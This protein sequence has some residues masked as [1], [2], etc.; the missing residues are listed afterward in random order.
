MITDIHLQNFRSYTDESFELSPGVN[1][2]V[3]PNASGKTNLL[4]AILVSSKGRSY[5]ASDA[6][7]VQFNKPSARIAVHTQSNDTRIVFIELVGEHAIKQY[8]INDHSL[9]RMV[10]ARTLPVVLFEPNHLDVLD[11]P[12]EL[13]R[14]WLDDLLEQIQPGFGQLRQQYKRAVAQRNA[15]LKSEKTP[16]PTQLFAWDFRL[17]ELGEKIALGRSHLIDE[18]NEDCQAV[19][20]ELSHS[21]VSLEFQYMPCVRLETYATDLL[22]KL[23][24]SLLH[25]RQRGFTTYGPHREDMAVIMGGH[26]IQGTVS[27]GEARTLMLVMKMLE[28]KLLKQNRETNPIFLLDD[29][30]S[31]LDGARRQALTEFL[32]PYQTFITTTDADVVIQHFTQTTNVI[33]TMH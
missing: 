32:Q 31:E 12:P 2:I 16:S 27:R 18:L 10:Q 26:P 33:P 22:A 30:F 15:L 17:S 20:D 24:T 23:E 9:K 6:E 21:K 28:M 7:L 14:Q 13:R 19:Y 1:I 11:G 3:G 29:V 25:D 8:K 4:E 5:R